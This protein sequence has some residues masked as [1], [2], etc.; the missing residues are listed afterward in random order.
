[1]GEALVLYREHDHRRFTK[2][3]MKPENCLRGI[4][5]TVATVTCA[6]FLASCRT[7]GTQIDGP[8]DQEAGLIGQYHRSD[9]MWYF[10]LNLASDGTCEEFF[11]QVALSPS[12]AAEQIE[13]NQYR[14]KGTWRLITP[15]TIE[16]VWPNRTVL[17]HVFILRGRAFVCDQ[18]ADNSIDET[19][20]LA[21]NLPAVE[22]GFIF[23]Q[24]S[25]S[26]K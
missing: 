19:A 20:K 21:M 1:M 16:I 13:Q 5:I 11:H 7:A 22:A 10:T 18:P 14:F 23:Y 24:R 2:N 17:R 25:L 8:I 3:G 12:E 26:A 9:T 4:F 15:G 6:L